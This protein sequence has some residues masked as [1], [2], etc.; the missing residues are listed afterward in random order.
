[1]DGAFG[2][3]PLN[4][5][6]GGYF[7]ADEAK[8]DMVRLLLEHGADLRVI[9]ELLG[10]SSIARTAVF[11]YWVPVFGVGFAAL[12]L[13]LFSLAEAGGAAAE[14]DELLSLVDSRRPKRPPTRPPLFF[15][16]GG[17][18]LRFF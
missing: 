12:L 3:T 17:G 8:I 2:S 4:E 15:F 16:S 7:D 14:V 5:A 13:V 18:E 1:M 10:P 11:L 6:I 9:P